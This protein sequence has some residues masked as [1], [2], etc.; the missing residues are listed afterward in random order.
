M[1]LCALPL[2]IGAGGGS[3]A[4]CAFGANGQVPHPTA[5]TRPDNS[6]MAVR[7]VEHNSLMR[8]VLPWHVLSCPGR[9]HCSDVHMPSL[10][11]G[12]VHLPKC[13]EEGKTRWP[14]PACLYVDLL[15]RATIGFELDGLMTNNNK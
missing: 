15:L 11:Q 3:C 7:D 5:N 1:F 4:V 14:I 12:S 13:A 9:R 2:L 10:G 8:S 6:N